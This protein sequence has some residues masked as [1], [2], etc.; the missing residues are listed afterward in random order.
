MSGKR[1]M[2]ARPAAAPA[3]AALEAGAGR[4]MAMCCPEL[5]AIEPGPAG[6]AVRAGCGAAVW[7]RIAAQR[8]EQVIAA[9]TEFCPWVEAVEPGVCAFGARGPARYFG[10]ETV[11]ARK[12]IAALADAGEQAR[13]GAADGLFAALLAARGAERILVIP[14]GETAEFLARQPVSVLAGQVPDGHDLAGLLSRLGLRTLGD[15]AALPAG[16][17]AG[18]FGAAG[19]AAHRLACGLGAPPLAV[20]PPARTCP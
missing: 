5:G 1:V 17:V 4:V 16:D 20:R 2:S 19:E 13:V 18:R 14:P 6:A 3:P 11:L 10:G 15:L 7:A 9:V 12:I 8:F